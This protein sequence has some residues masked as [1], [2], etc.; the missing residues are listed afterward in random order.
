MHDH[1]PK[2]RVSIP[3]WGLK[4][5][6][7]WST[8][9]ASIHFWMPVVE[10]SRLRT[11]AS[12]RKRKAWFTLFLHM[13]PVPLLLSWTEKWPWTNHIKNS[14]SPQGPSLLN[15]DHSKTY[16]LG[17]G[18]RLTL[19]NVCE[20]LQCARQFAKH[21]TWR[22]PCNLCNQPPKEVGPI[23]IPISQM[24]KL[25]LVPSYGCQDSRLFSHMG[26]KF[27]QWLSN[28]RISWRACEHHKW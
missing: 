13:T 2:Y 3:H 21:V 12:L 14:L 23:I 6:G 8:E 11:S 24:M 17:S 22:I 19:M 27:S 9:K 4:T 26:Y 16:V 28:F 1:L 25:F 7:S 20:C 10:H 18:G 15:S 5:R